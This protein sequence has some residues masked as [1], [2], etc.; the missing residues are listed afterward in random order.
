MFFIIDSVSKVKIVKQSS[1]KKIII[2][3]TMKDITKSLF[4]LV[5]LLLTAIKL[6]NELLLIKYYNKLRFLP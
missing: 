4:E 1:V 5:S 3:F 2:A 6:T